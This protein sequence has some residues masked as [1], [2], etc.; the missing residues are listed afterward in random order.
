[1]GH[2][3][4]CE[5]C[6][7]ELDRKTA[8]KINE[9]RT[10][11]PNHHTPARCPQCQFKAEREAEKKREE[12]EEA[13][14]QARVPEL[15][16]DAG[17]PDGYRYRRDS[18]LS[19]VEGGPI[20]EHAA[21]WVWDHRRDNLLLSGKTGMGKSTSACYAAM[22]LIAEH[23]RVR[24]IK[25]QR[26]LCEWS[27]ARKNDSVHGEQEFFGR[28]RRLDLLILDEVVGKTKDTDSRREMMIE[29]LDEIASGEIKMRLWM[30]GNYRTNSIDALFGEE[31]REPSRRRIEENFVCAGITENSVEVF[32]VW[33]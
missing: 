8:E 32:H 1:M 4:K 26:L 28:F 5:E 14:Y 29:L 7:R 33:P 31:N 16:A 6:G 12:T 21:S 9:I 19:T 13:E 24:Y 27:E 15:I 20:V 17:I 30:L 2:L 18:G 3:M 10:F 22:R 23:K 25:L 11:F